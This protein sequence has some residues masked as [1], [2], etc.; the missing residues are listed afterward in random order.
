MQHNKSNGPSTGAYIGMP[1][2]R[3]MHTIA[4]AV[5]IVSALT[6]SHAMALALGRVAV[7]SVLGE[8]LRAEID[9]PSISPEE[10]SSLQIGVAPPDRFRAASMEFNPLLTEVR[11]ELV[12][13]PNGQFVIR[14]SSDRIVTEPFLDIV[15]QASWSSGQLLR[16]YT[17]LFD[18]PNLRPAPAPLLPAA[19]TPPVVVEVR[20]AMPVPPTAS[21]APPAVIPPATASRPA[22][23]APPAEA[24]RRVEVQRGDTASGIAMSQ[25]PPGV[26]L[27]QMLIAM[28]RANPGAF[29]NNNVNRLRAGAILEMPDAAAAS[30]IPLGEARQLVQ[31]QSRDF[32]EFRR[33]LASMAPAQDAPAATR[34]AEGVV[35][36]EVADQQPTATA[37]DRLTLAQAGTATAEA[38]QIAQERQQEATQQRSDELNRNLQ[39][40]E[41]LREAIATTPATEAAPAVESSAEATEPPA[42][43]G[44]AVES[45]APLPTPAA[46]PTTAV[47]PAPAATSFIQSLITHP[48]ALPAGGGL[49]A[50]LALLGLLRWRRQ[51]AAQAVETEQEPDTAAYEQA[52]GQTV[53]TNEDAP[54]SSMMYSPSQLDAGGDVDP[55]AEADVYLAYGRD[56]QAEEILLEAIRL[57]PDRL[58]VRLKLLEIYAS[59][60]D[61]VAFNAAAQ[62]VHALTAGEGEDWEQARAMGLQLDPDNPLY[63]SGQPSAAV[64]SSPLSAPPDIDLS[65][66]SEPPASAGD[67]DDLDKLLQAEPPPASNE[68]DLDLSVEPPASPP[69][70]PSEQALDSFDF[71]LDTGTGNTQT[72]PAK[73][74]SPSASDGLDFDLDLTELESPPTQQPPVPA[75]APDLPD[76]IKELSLDL[77]LDLES[78]T[79]PAAA[80]VEAPPAKTDI[81]PLD[82]LEID[83]NLGGNDPLQTKLSLAEEFDAIGDTDGAR[84]LAEE[85]EA[86]ATGELKE[87]A[88]AFLARLS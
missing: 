11:F 32:N 23:S 64:D 7:Q 39:E 77:D 15:V 54:V 58:P 8:P 34:R 82:D 1:K 71:D 69:P 2:K 83:E 26:S 14:L 74:V 67:A 72:P 27:D 86:E 4:A 3:S 57:H 43:P 42:V 65:F 60:N 25:M 19:P 47:P 29:I 87:R 22:V 53:D 12:Q 9:V 85:V 78:A 80:P 61:A 16:G 17:M 62:D 49:V 35:Q 36:A 40:L 20:P 84:S 45:A 79:P 41:Q 10:A 18:P 5:A 33:R 21:A 52:E 31:A 75:A 50:L 44:L 37:Q 38:D 51:K 55:V 56:K 46:P 63:L 13:R 48:Y 28:L 88:R 59:R 24:V 66:D 73:E 30:A 70:Q 68:F 81:D 6:A 76:E